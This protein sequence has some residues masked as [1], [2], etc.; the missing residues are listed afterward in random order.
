MACFYVSSANNAFASMLNEIRKKCPALF[1]ISFNS[2]EHLMLQSCELY[3]DDNH[4]DYPR[5]AVQVCVTNEHSVIWNN[6]VLKYID[7]EMCTCLAY[8]SKKIKK[9]GIKGTVTNVVMIPKSG[10][11]SVIDA[12]LVQ[13][14]IVK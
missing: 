12:I 9:Y 8:G 10:L 1:L 7:S 2:L 5:N 13:L 4:V 11:N 14:V 3:I 6:K